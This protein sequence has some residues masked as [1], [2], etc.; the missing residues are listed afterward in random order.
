MFGQR[1]DHVR[2]AYKEKRYD[3]IVANPFH[4]CIAIFL[5]MRSLVLRL[6]PSATEVFFLRK[7][8]SAKSFCRAESGFVFSVFSEYSD[9]IKKF[10]QNRCR[11]DR[12]HFF[13]SYSRVVQE[14][15]RNGMSACVLLDRGK[16]VCVFFVTRLECEA[17]QVQYRY[18][19]EGNEV[20]VTDIYTMKEYR[21]RGIYS[22]L[23]H[24]AIKYFANGGPVV[25]VMWIMRHN[26]ATIQAQVKI[27]FSEIFQ[28]V[29]LFSWLGFKKITVNPTK[30]ALKNLR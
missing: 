16:V 12:T 10:V 13:E 22:Q 21:R 25:I 17:E 20:V 8:F 6:V 2:I 15:F 24:E 9:E 3:E 19:P 29:R 5:G 23:L 11:E 7:E 26:Q 1:M 30:R 28:S 18:L 27:G 4:L 14:R